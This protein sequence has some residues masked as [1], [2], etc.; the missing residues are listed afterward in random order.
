MTPRINYFLKYN[1][2]LL[3]FGLLLA[4]FSSFGQTFLLSLYVPSI[5]E[6]LGVSNAEFGTIY[7]VAT[8]GSALTLPW[9]GGYFD[10]IDT[11]RYTLMV[12]GGL[13]VALLL[14]SFS[15][16]VILVILGFYGLRLFGQGLMT[17]T[18]VSSMA[19]YFGADR[20]KAIGAASLG[21][22]A[23]EASLPI[24]I[25]LLMGVIGWRG[26]LQVSALTCALVV[27]PLAL[28]LLGR[29]KTRLRAYRMQNHA[30]QNQ[31]RK[32]DIRDILRDRRFWI[33]TPVVFMIGFTNTAI[34]FFQLKLGEAKGWSPEW[35][36]GSL[37]AF[38]IAGALGMTGIGS[39]VDRFTARRLFP[40]NMIPYLFGLLALILF[41]HRLVY[42]VALTLIGLGH[43]TGRTIKDAM[44]AE[45][46]GSDIIG[47]V[48]SFFITVMV[49]STAIGPV[50]FGILLDLSVSYTAIFTGVLITTL[51]AFLNGLRKT[52]KLQE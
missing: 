28:F 4:F 23:G 10:T 30:A 25:T 42:P 24:L 20:G 35:V 6:L 49:V 46:Y 34:F 19:R 18:S 8:V 15:Y 47:Q 31:T 14:L 41:D 27:A 1:L 11:K 39:L 9:I 40:Y 50:V 48:R 43:G 12:I 38:A 29:S 52:T 37:S 36:A 21:H 5:E 7:A 33:I 45:L 22:P 51:L 44:L 3:A 2:S 17:H 32:V 16:H 26:A 13:M